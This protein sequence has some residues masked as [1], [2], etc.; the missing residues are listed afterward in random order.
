[1]EQNSNVLV[2]F[3]SGDGYQRKPGKRCKI[4]HVLWKFMKNE[5]LFFS[6]FDDFLE[7]TKNT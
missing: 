6:R 1:M 2:F 7:M 5:N 4:F 3:C